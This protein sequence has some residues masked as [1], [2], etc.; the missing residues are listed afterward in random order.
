MIKEFALIKLVSTYT[1][2]TNTSKHTHARAEGRLVWFDGISTIVDFFVPN[3]FYT[4][5][6]FVN[7]FC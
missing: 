3:P 5:I 4:Y 7:R 2:Y 6:E 1:R